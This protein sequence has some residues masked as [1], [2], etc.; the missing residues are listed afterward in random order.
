MHAPDSE[1]NNLSLFTNGFAALISNTSEEYLFDSFLSGIADSTQ[2]VLGHRGLS[3]QDLLRLPRLEND[4]LAENDVYLDA[5][6]YA[7]GEA[8]QWRLYIG[9]A[10][11]EFGALQRWYNYFLGHC[12]TRH[13]K[14]IRQPGRSM[15]LRC[16]AHYGLSPIAWLPV[17]A[18]GIFMIYFG[19]IDDPGFRAERFV[20]FISDH[21]YNAINDL[22]LQCGLDVPIAR[23]LNSTWTFTQGWRG[24]GIKIGAKCVD[25]PR[26]VLD[27]NDPKFKRTEWKY[28]DPS[29]PAADV[30]ICVNCRLYQRRHSGEHRPAFLEEK[31]QRVKATD[32][33]PCQGPECTSP[34]SHL[35]EGS[36]L[37]VC[38]GHD[39]QL[40]QGKPL[41][42]IEAEDKSLRPKKPDHC[43]GPEC[44][45]T[46]I[47]WRIDCRM[48]LCESHYCQIKAGNPL[49]EIG[50]VRNSR[51]ASKPVASKP[52]AS[53]PVAS[54]PVAS[55]PVAS[56]PVAS[57]PDASKPDH[58]EGPECTYSTK[59]FKNA[60][61]G[62]YL[63]HSHRLQIQSGKP[64]T[65]L[66]HRKSTAT[67]PKP[68]H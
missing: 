15:N 30:V 56:K 28:A 10:V 24:V 16:L 44:S 58:C 32:K 43:T 47:Y 22:R 18:E 50:T 19:T 36:G 53:K 34:Y 51:A 48:F 31:R 35:H 20:R 7:P 39:A 14:A 3:I 45:K 26:T 42:A 41:T 55:K 13:G 38:W 63:C 17:F 66:L 12:T 21:L 1:L 6:E 23:G 8:H 25:C 67:R 46:L 60:K 37:W 62:K 5:V 61:S 2:A 57:K 64:L 68:D 9:S 52:V 49:T 33:L 65:Q 40:K 59:I 27:F 54:K 4:I 29:C 11:A